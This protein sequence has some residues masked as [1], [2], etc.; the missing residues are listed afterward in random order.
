MAGVSR[1]TVSRALA[2]DP[3]IKKET[4][5][6]IRGIADQLGYRVNTVARSL[7]SGRSNVIGCLMPDSLNHYQTQLLQ[8]LKQALA[9]EGFRLFVMLSSGRREQT[10]EDIELLTSYMVD[11]LLW[12]VSFADEAPVQ[13]AE[14][15]RKVPLVLLGGEAG[16][17]CDQVLLAN[18]RGGYEL[19]RYLIG[20]GHHEI[21]FLGD[22]DFGAQHGRMAGY[23]QALRDSNILVSPQWVIHC[24]SLND[25]SAALD[26]WLTLTPRP[27]ALV[28]GNDALAV[29]I[30]GYLSARGFQIPEKVSLAGFENQPIAS[31][32]A[33]ALTTVDLCPAKVARASV[34]LLMDRIGCQRISEVGPF[35]GRQHMVEPELRIGQ[36]SGICMNEGVAAMN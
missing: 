32:L 11:G 4:A 23:K 26:Q 7:K 13:A 25:V 6:R 16:S 27:S 36:T 3:K 9:E 28:A 17:D 15:A 31:Q 12:D 24:S 2:G 30:F 18:R 29:R 21:A 10:L 20:L 19:T 33:P 14:I 8:N 22:L 35:F 1:P 34:R 5:Q